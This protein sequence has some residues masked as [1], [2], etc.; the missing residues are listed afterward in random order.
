[1]EIASLGKFGLIDRLTA[2]LKTVNPSTIKGIGD[3]A[4]VV[5]YPDKN[6]LFTSQLL[7]EGIH[8]D[9]T[10]VALKFLGYKAA[11]A[12]FSDIYALNGFPGQL[13]V[14]V[15]VSKRFSV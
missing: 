14:S 3:D 2:N 15:G 7:L 8:F 11:S 5:E 4:A 1:M 10:Y 13:R 12:C 6:V 9:L